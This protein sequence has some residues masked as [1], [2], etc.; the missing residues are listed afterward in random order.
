MYLL[1]QRSNSLKYQS[2]IVEAVH[3]YGFLVCAFVNIVLFRFVFV[4]NF[5]FLFSSG[6]E[7]CDERRAFRTRKKF[8]KCQRIRRLKGGGIM[9][10]EML[11]I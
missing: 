6:K 11:P 5:F 3:N 1:H 8:N 7:G 9:K 4:F 10:N 2:A